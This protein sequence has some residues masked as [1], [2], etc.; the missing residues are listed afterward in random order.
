MNKGVFLAYVVDFPVTTIRAVVTQD[1][2]GLV[3]ERTQSVQV[4]LANDIK[5]IYDVSIIRKLP[6]ASGKL[7]SPALGTMGGGNIP[8]NPADGEADNA[9]ESVFQFVLTLPVTAN[10]RNLGERVYVRFDLG[11]EALAWQW[12]RLGRQLFLRRFSV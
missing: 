7:P 1:N 9:F 8:V 6:A 3:R 10:A 11:E 12:Y 2:I 5:T 4:R